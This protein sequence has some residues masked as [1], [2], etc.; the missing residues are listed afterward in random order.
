[1]RGGTRQALTVT[2]LTHVTSAGRQPEARSSDDGREAEGQAK[3][4]YPLAR[5]GSPPAES[6]PFL[7]Q[8]AHCAASLQQLQKPQ[9]LW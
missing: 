8:C 2:P 7:R 3:R 4:V 5:R 1:M 6:S 9:L